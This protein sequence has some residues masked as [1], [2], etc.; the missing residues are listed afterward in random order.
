M[1]CF[2]LFFLK[3]LDNSKFPSHCYFS[4]IFVSLVLLDVVIYECLYLNFIELF[5][6]HLFSYA[7]IF[8]ILLLSLYLLMSLQCC[9]QVHSFLFQER[10]KKQDI[11]GRTGDRI[12]EG[13]IQQYVLQIFLEIFFPLPNYPNPNYNELRIF[14]QLGFAQCVIE[15]SL[16]F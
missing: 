16:G 5:Y 1:L 6:C 2:K 4:I 11:Q 3:H 7:S 13:K 10:N 12:T 9:P 15:V 14:F 8:E